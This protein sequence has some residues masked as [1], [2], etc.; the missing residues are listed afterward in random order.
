MNRYEFIAA[1]VSAAIITACVWA[2]EPSDETR[3]AIRVVAEAKRIEEVCKN[4]PMPYA[5]A[6]RELKESGLDINLINLAQ[7][8]VK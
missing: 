4:Q 6:D 3:D 1:F 2:G 8:F 5:C 7:Q